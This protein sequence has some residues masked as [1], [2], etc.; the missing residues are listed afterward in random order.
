M[1]RRRQFWFFRSRTLHETDKMFGSVSLLLS[2]DDQFVPFS[3]W[4]FSGSINQREWPICGSQKQFSRALY[5]NYEKTWTL[6]GTFVLMTHFMGLSHKWAKHVTCR[7][8]ESLKQISHS[9]TL[10]RDQ[11]VTLAT[12]YLV[13]D[14]PGSASLG[15][16]NLCPENSF[17]KNCHLTFQK[18]SLCLWSS[19]ELSLSAL[20]SLGRACTRM[21]QR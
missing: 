14:H 6:F 12:I 20:L 21:P 5:C 10:E 18:F 11:F 1:K 4:G 2:E 15:G 16:G 7:V 8:D 3:R 9:I 13:A 17:E 19:G